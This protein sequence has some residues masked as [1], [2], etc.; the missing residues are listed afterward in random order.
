[1]RTR[2]DRSNDYGVSDDDDGASQE[3]MP[4]EK[5]LHEI[6]AFLALVRM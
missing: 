4:F 5:V 1:M 3:E 6:H 2:A